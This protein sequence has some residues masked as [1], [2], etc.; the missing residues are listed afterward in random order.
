M[1]QLEQ[2]TLELDVTKESV[3][4]LGKVGKGT[5][6]WVPLANGIFAKAVWES[7]KFLVNIGANVAVP[8][9]VDEVHKLIQEQQDEAA[10]MR[11]EMMGHAQKLV[12]MAASLEKELQ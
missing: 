7:D 6:V 8:K 11:S 3:S 10:K 9:S 4:D 5:S 12:E 2:Q 1:Q